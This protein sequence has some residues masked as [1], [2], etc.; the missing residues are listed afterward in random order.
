MENLRSAVQKSSAILCCCI[1]N[2]AWSGSVDS[3]SPINSP[4]DSFWTQK[5]LLGD[6]GGLRTRLEQ[7]GVTFYSEYRDDF[8]GNVIGTD[9]N[10]NDRGHSVNFGRFRLNLDVDLMKL[11]C[12]DGEFFFSAAWQY[13]GNLSG[14]YLNVHTLTSSI[15]GTDSERIDQLWYQQGFFDSR[16][17]IKIGQIAAANEFGA[18]DFFDI[19]YND[20]LGY[21]PNTN[22]VTHQPFSPA[23]KPGVIATLDLRDIIPGLYIKGGAFTAIRDPY[24]PDCYGVD[25]A[26]DCD[27]G[28]AFAGEVGYKEQKTNY[29]GV[30]KLGFN[31]TNQ[32][33]F[34][35]D[36]TGQ[37]LKGNYNGYMT[38]EKTVFHPQ[39]RN[40]KL[41]NTSRELDLLLQIFGEPDD[42]NPVDVE[43]TFGGR[44][45]RLIPGRDKDKVGFGFIYSHTSHQQSLANQIVVGRPR[46][47][48]DS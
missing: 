4:P 46:W 11:A 29:D 41:D 13:G 5:Y 42:R 6:W 16:L 14:R 47:R 10:G 23:G 28:A 20:E 7:M 40:G 15:A 32:A 27:Q 24:H 1:A 34:T 48:R 43:V 45:T 39:D 21:S 31:Y 19:L 22:F 35:Q 2:C 30:Y 38:I 25:Y 33:G 3:S 9:K 12:I 26:S 8:Q 18:T 17:K 44:Y 37:R 36:R